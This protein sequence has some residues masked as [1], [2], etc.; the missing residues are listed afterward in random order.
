MALSLKSM[1]VLARFHF[2][3]KVRGEPVRRYTM[4]NPYH[5]VS[6]APSLGN[7]CRAATR[8]A[9]KRFLSEEAPTLP[10]P[11]CTAAQCTC[12]YQHHEDRRS[13]SRRSA[14]VAGSAGRFWPGAEKR[15]GRGRRE[16]DP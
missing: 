13:G 4:G 10:L 6:I 3:S 16:T 9:G 14:D 1:S 5:A 15:D 2:K 7:S 8:H 12:R 11:E